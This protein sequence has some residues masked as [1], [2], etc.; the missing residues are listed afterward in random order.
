MFLKREKEKYSLHL[1][2]CFCSLDNKV[3]W[4][5]CVVPH[6]EEKSFIF[7]GMLVSFEIFGS[8]CW[9][10]FMNQIRIEKLTHFWYLRFI[11]ATLQH[12]ASPSTRMC[13]I[14]AKHREEKNISLLWGCKAYHYTER[15]LQMWFMFTCEKSIMKQDLEKSGHSA[16][17]GTVKK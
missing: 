16:W 7:M 3:F 4:A 11:S 14:C 10:Q 17:G 12:F 1:K 2:V 6:A 5:T 13:R 15:L 9:N 8:R